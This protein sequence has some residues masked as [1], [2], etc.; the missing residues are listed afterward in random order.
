M[1]KSTPPV[2]LPR[3]IASKARSAGDNSLES[4]QDI[5]NP[6]ARAERMSLDV[7]RKQGNYT[8]VIRRIVNKEGPFSTALFSYVQVA[9]SAW[10]I[11]A[12]DDTTGQFSPEVTSLARQVEASMDTVRDYSR[13]YSDMEGMDTLKT[14][15]LREAAISGAIGAELVLN[16]ALL[17]ERVQVTPTETIV[18]TS[19]GDGTKYPKQPGKATGGGDIILD[20][21][22]FFYSRVHPD[23]NTPYGMSMFVAA[24]DQTDYFREFMEDMRKVLRRAGQPRMVIKLMAEAVQAALPAE[25]KEDPKKLSAAMDNV[26]TQVQEVVNAMSPEDA[27]I[28]YDYA[29][30]TMLKGEGEKADFKPL[31]ETLAGLTATSMKSHPSIIGMR[32]GGSQSLSNTESLIFLKMAHALQVPAAEVMSRIMTLAVRLYGAKAHVKVVFDPIDLR[33]KLE[34]EAQLSMRQARVLEQLSLGL[35]TDDQA[36]V[37]LGTF[38]RPAGS[39]D[40]SGTMFLQ[41]ATVDPS[42]ASPNNGPQE[43]ALTPEGPDRAGGKSQ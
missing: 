1:A 26:L 14:K 12:Y 30:T 22:N 4:K 10:K 9:S 6:A 43:R 21:P 35:I 19:R 38:P 34:Q 3:R 42:K 41:A 5:S 39:Q 16:K 29:E 2:V 23:S 7:L 17:P 27:L 15:L 37:E 24:L 13:G 31:I 25:A 28:M 32:I 40:L 18:F 36:A 11:C 8:E 33:P 20:I